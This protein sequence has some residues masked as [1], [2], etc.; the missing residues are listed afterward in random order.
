MRKQQNALK[1]YEQTA[2]AKGNVKMTGNCKFMKSRQE[3]DKKW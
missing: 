3:N 1:Y 2:M